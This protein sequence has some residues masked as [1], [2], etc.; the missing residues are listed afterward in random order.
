MRRPSTSR[1]R[2]WRAPKS[3]ADASLALLELR[4]ESLI[5][6]GE[7]DR[8]L[9][10]AEAMLALAERSG[11]RLHAQALICL[12]RVQA[13]VRRHRRRGRDRRA[14]AQGRADAAAGS[15]CRA[16][17]CSNLAAAQMRTAARAPPAVENATRRRA[18]F[19]ALGDEMQRGRAL[20]VDRLRAGRSRPQ[21]RKRARGRRGARARAPDR[22]SLGRGLGA[23]HPLAPEHRS[24]EAPARAAP[25]AR[26]LPGASGHVSG[27]AAIYNNLALA[28]RAL[29]L[30]RRSSRMAHRTIEIRRRLH[31]FDSV[32]NALDH[33]RRQRHRSRVTPRPRA[34]T[35]P[36]SRPQVACR[37]RTATASGRSAMD[38]LAGLIAIAERD[39]AAAVPF[40]EKALRPCAA[41]AGD[42]LPDPGPD[43]SL[44]GTSAARATRRRRSRPRAAPSTCIGARESR[45]MGAG[46]SPAHVWW[47]HHQAL[48]AKA[49]ARKPQGAAK[50]P[51]GCCSKASAR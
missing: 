13:V 48:A 42:E 44:R 1:Q 6:L 27:Q 25:G 4:A 2:R 23:Q 47:W 12:A 43:R 8:A 10:D 37:A 45:A 32:A 28:Y 22:R 46:L 20:W 33:R 34:S 21:G 41:D 11:R 50:P 9:A 35:S 51:T 3:D 39:G 38:W 49:R 26:R 24:R 31:D 5:A 17:P 30:Y 18:P 29:G 7:V 16:V 40:L 36:S 15:R 14:G 19:A